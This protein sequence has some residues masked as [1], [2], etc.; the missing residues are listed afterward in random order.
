M[1]VN[2]VAGLSMSPR[3]PDGSYL[4]FHHFIYRSLITIGKVVKVDHPRYGLI[5]KKVI[6]IDPQGN[7]WLEGLNGHSVSSL[8]IG[9]IKLEMIV[10]ISVYNI[11]SKSC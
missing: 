4:I 3:I 6:N 5:V 8:E 9:A 10:G 1:S 11:K 2:R 7:Y